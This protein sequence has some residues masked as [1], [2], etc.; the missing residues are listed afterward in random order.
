ML[1]ELPLRLAGEVRKKLAYILDPKSEHFDDTFV[2]ATALNPQLAVL[3]DEELLAEAKRGIEKA[4][5][6]ASHLDRGL[7]SR[8]QVVDRLRDT[9]ECASSSRLPS[10]QTAAPALQQQQQLQQSLVLPAKRSAWKSGGG[11]DA[12]LAA[13]VERKSGGTKLNGGGGG[14]GDGGGSVE[15]RNSVSPSTTAGGSVDGALSTSSLYPDLVQ[16]AAQRRKLLNVRKRRAFMRKKKRTCK[17]R[18]RTANSTAAVTMQRRLLARILKMCSTM[19]VL[20]LSLFQARR[21][22]RAFQTAFSSL[23]NG[24]SP[25]ASSQP[26]AFWQWGAA[27][28]PQLA[29]LALELLTT[30][31]SP[32]LLGCG[33]PAATM[34]PPPPPP[35]ATDD[36]A[37][38]ASL[39]FDARA[40]IRRA[41][42]TEKHA[43]T[44]ERDALIRFNPNHWHNSSVAS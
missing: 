22:R 16:A 13:V 25:N 7:F 17:T 27:K 43:E 32:S 44:L 9:D 34:P 37:S 15:I 18:F 4:V 30:P 5:R 39:R 10:V 1:G 19:C 42:A 12:L 33:V 35:A 40:F 28:C 23:F 6:N 38:T 31:C 26:L 21:F 8:F 14:D 2:Q 29:D 36:G 41:A 11:V 3:L 20:L 24:A